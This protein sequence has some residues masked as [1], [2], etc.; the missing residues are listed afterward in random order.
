MKFCAKVR[1]VSSCHRHCKYIRKI[2][3]KTQKNPLSNCHAGLMI[4]QIRLL[5]L[6]Y[7]LG[8]NKSVNVFY[9]IVNTPRHSILLTLRTYHIH[10]YDEGE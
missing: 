7:S 10:T 1:I 9:S 2:D 8:L 6:N 3:T 5:F 4:S